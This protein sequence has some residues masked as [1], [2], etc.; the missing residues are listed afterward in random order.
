MAISKTAFSKLYVGEVNGIV[1]DGA[2]YAA[3][4]TWT[5]I[6]STTDLGSIGPTS[7]LKELRH[8]NEAVVRRIGGVIDNGEVNVSCSANPSDPGQAIV[9]ANVGERAHFKL[10]MDD[11]PQGGTP[12]KFF[13]AAIVAEARHEL[14]TGDDVHELTIKLGVDGELYHVP[15]AS[16]V[17]MTPA[18][19]ALTGGTV[20]VA[21][22]A[23]TFAA[24]GGVGVPHYHVT[25]GELPPGLSLNAATGALTG[26][27]T[28][29]S[30]YAFT[31]TAYYTGEGILS[32]RYTI[33]IAP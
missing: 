25:E 14:K 16:L 29:A 6:G 23:A 4:T 32:Q 24:S 28:L 3:L 7:G 31:V 33:V 13:F 15:A 11:A 2:A 1:Y 26:T 20:S 27:P 21:Y 8:I 17:T 10:V 12:T 5:E 18:P 22:S 30:T 19:G 9:R